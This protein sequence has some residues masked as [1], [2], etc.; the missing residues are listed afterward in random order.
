[1][2]NGVL[3]HSDMAVL[4]KEYP[5][6]L[7]TWMLHLTEVFDLTFPLPKQPINIVPCLMSDEPIQVLL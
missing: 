4:W 1:M 6:D 7:H 5:R 2:Q 3:N